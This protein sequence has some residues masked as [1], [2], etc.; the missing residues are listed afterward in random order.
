M[1]VFRQRLKELRI[2]KQLSALT[3]SKELKVCH[4]TLLR[5]ENG[6]ILPSID[7]LYNIAVFFGVS[8]DYLLGLE[9]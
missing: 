9:D 2:E 1:E 6:Q 7:H 3:L 5:W 8:S 4:S